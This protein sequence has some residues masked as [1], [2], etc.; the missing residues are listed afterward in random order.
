MPSMDPLE[1]DR[2]TMRAMGHAVV[3]LLV[4]RIGTLHDQPAW[5]GATRAEMDA[6]LLE[7]PPEQPHDFDR[8]LRRLRGDVLAYGA[9]VDHPRFFAFVPGS[10]TWPGILGEAIAAAHQA[11]AGTWIIEKNSPSCRMALAKLS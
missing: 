11:F 2:E 8:L 3:D 6:R 10:P 9:R 1:L 4:D 5:R 7:A